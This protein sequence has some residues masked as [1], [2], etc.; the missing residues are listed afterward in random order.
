[1]IW[2]TWRQQRA[3]TL[4]AA[5]VFAIAVAVLVPTDLHIAST[6]VRYRRR[7]SLLRANS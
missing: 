5:F 6:V 4:I 2:L 3:E 7:G 1:V